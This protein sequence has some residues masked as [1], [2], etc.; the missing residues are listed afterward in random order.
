MA[1][2]SLHS[3][4]ESNYALYPGGTPP[5]C[6]EVRLAIL[7]RYL[8]G[9]MVL[10]MI[11]I[12]HVCKAE[13][14]RTIWRV[15]DAV[16]AALPTRC[17]WRDP[18]QLAI[19]EAGFRSISKTLAWIGQVAAL[20]GCHFTTIS[21]GVSVDNPRVYY[22]PRKGHFCTLASAACDHLRR[23]IDWSIECTPTTHDS[24]AFA[25]SRLGKIIANEGLPGA[26]FINGD[27]AYALGPHMVV[28]YN[29]PEYTNFDFYQS[30]NR[31]AIECA[32]GMLIR[33]WGILWRP[34]RVHHNR[35]GP[36]I[37]CCMRL[38]NLCIDFR[39]SEEKLPEM[40]GEDAVCV[41]GDGCVGNRMTETPIFDRYGRP[42]EYL[43]W[44]T[45]R[46]CPPNTEKGK[47]RED[48]RVKLDAAGAARPRI[49]ANPGPSE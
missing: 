42:L 48:L 26:Y 27:S 7:L 28:P 16:N 47:T 33:R 23:F 8:A 41:P 9:G 30:S 35:R 1:Q 3:C 13:V 15:M 36:L 49:R 29:I 32:F 43:D 21:P 46:K 2:S 20:D 44:G 31:M 24:A 10:D 39:I 38:H 17:P 6:P 22:V 11:L 37:G 40:N 4:A 5:I 45:K 14:Y 18:E 34:F 19:L 25:Q 12:Y